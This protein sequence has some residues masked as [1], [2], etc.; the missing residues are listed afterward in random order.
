METHLKGKS[1]IA[2]SDVYLAE[3]G[4]RICRRVSD[5][6]KRRRYCG[7]RHGVLVSV[8]IQSADAA[9]RDDAGCVGIGGVSL[10]AAI[11]RNFSLSIGQLSAGQEGQKLC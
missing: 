3:D 5:L 7:G 10:R 1:G 9:Y 8:A 4:H 6:A 2:H 11:G